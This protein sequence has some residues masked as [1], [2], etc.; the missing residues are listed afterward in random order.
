M[1]AIWPL[2]GVALGAGLTYFFG[3]LTSSAAAKREDVRAEKADA[4]RLATIGREHAARALEIVRLAHGEAWRRRPEGT[5]YDIDTEDLRLDGAEGEI[6]L[7][8]DP[9][10]RRRLASV[11][12]VVRYPWA[13]AN[14]SYSEGYPLDTQREGLY[15]LRL[16]LAAYVR[17]EPT[18]QEPD[19]LAQLAKAND[20]AHKE[21]EDWEAEQREADKKEREAEARKKA[22]P[23]KRPTPRKKPK[24]S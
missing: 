4:L 23:R 14:S 15:L 20:D 5:S 6:D 10:L 1:E 7:I 12:Q 19:R 3:R 21:R 18:P 2:I 17:E 13:L 9:V 11:L 24:E 16:A 22:A 8:P